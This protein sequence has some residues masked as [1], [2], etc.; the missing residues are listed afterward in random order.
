[1]QKRQ[2]IMEIVGTTAQLIMET[3]AQLIME[4]V[5]TTAQ[6]IMEMPV[7]MKQITVI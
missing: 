6:L 4:I 3:T 2:L 1:M 7:I 5:E